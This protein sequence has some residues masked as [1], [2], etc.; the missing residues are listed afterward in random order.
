VTQRRAARH[1]GIGKIVSGGQTG[2]DRAALDVAL[3]LGIECG[4]WCPQGRRAEDGRIPERYP[5]TE[6]ESA[7]YSQRTQRNV[8]E[9]DATLI[10]VCGE[11]RGGTLLTQRTAGRIGKPCLSVDVN[12]PVAPQE[13][14]EWLSQHAVRILNVAGPRETQSPGIGQLAT[15]LLHE[16]FASHR[17][18]RQTS[19]RRK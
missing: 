11:P 10:L 17:P 16:L 1:F 13:V 9:S 8:R 19:R 14:R 12:A 6:T 15:Q 7:A 3:A 2:V 18:P 5:L 4:G